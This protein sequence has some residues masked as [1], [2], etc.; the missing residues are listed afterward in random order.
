MPVDG[1]A[2]RLLSGLLAG[3]ADHDVHAV[4]V[5]RVDARM[6]EAPTV[7]DARRGGHVLIERGTGLRGGDLA[8]MVR[9]VALVIDLYVVGAFEGRIVRVSGLRRMPCELALVESGG[10]RTALLLAGWLRVRPPGIVVLADIPE[11]PVRLPHDVGG[12]IF[13]VSVDEVVG[14]AAGVGGGGDCGRRGVGCELHDA[15]RVPGR[16]GRV[17]RTGGAGQPRAQRGRGDQTG[18]ES[19]EESHSFFIPSYCF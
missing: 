8:V 5:R 3:F 10:Q 7:H 19:C 11:F 18:D 16:A 13:E 2:R 9:A 4:D 6:F 14:Q 15:F 1:G 17:H 12:R